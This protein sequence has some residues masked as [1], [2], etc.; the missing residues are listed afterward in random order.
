MGP[1]RP[2]QAGCVPRWAPLCPAL[3]GA[4]AGPPRAGA[5]LALASAARRVAPPAVLLEGAGRSLQRSPPQQS[6]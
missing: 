3:A 4:M 5:P 6:A 2:D 1:P